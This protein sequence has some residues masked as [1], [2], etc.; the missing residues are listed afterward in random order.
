MHFGH[1]DTMVG[2]EDALLADNDEMNIGEIG[3]AG[4][5]SEKS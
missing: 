3:L 2:V 4:W 1:E 5:N